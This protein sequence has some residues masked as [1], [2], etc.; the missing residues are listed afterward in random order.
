MPRRVNAQNIETAFRAATG[1][2]GRSRRRAGEPHPQFS[3]HTDCRFRGKE[4][5][6][7]ISSEIAGAS[8]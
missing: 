5:A 4:P 8:W 6:K 7:H 1:A 3:T 2:C